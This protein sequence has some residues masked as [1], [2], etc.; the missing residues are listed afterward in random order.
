MFFTIYK[1]T[2]LVNQKF[3]I[4]SH[5]TS[6]LEDG[7]LGS[8]KYLKYAIEKHGREKF[9]KEI[10]FVFDNPDD[11][12]AKEAEL[13]D[14]NFLS[15]ENTYNLKVGGFGGFD[16]LNDVFDNPSHKKE[17]LLMMEKKR[18]V[19]YPN[20]T[21]K[22]PHTAESRSKISEGK[23]GN[24]I[25]VGKKHSEETKAKMRISARNRIN[26]NKGL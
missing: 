24:K 6:D 5:R 23:K 20:G 13:V 9:V 17:H 10:L 2:C 21:F 11:M 7:Y 19:E 14:K 15:E 18:K 3:Y 25:W 8:G 26:A 16:Y 1:T 4:G 22:R 12:Y